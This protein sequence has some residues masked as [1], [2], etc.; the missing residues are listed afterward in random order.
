MAE[1]E[2]SNN[3]QQLWYIRREGKVRGPFPCGAVR[4]SVLLGRVRLDDEASMDRTNWKRVSS[5][6]DVVPPEV[7]KALESGDLETLDLLRMREDERSGR[8]RRTAKDDVEFKERRHGERRRQ[9]DKLVTRHREAKAELLDLEERRKKPYVGMLVVSLLVIAAVGGG[10]YIGS[11][12]AIQE[13]DCFAAPAPGVNWRNCR[14]DETVAE[15]SDLAGAQ[16][17]NAVLRQARLSGSSF[18]GADLKYSDFTG[19]DLSYGEFI[20]AA[21]KGVN[22]QNAD[23]TNA[24]LTGSDLSFA[25]LSG[26]RLG[27]AKLGWA[28]LDGAIWIDGKTCGVGSLGG[29]KK[30]PE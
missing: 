2:N 3:K 8:E 19:A 4:R 17:N 27:G 28:R 22:L 23:L 14:L 12:Q 21:M 29:C 20:N 1:Q 11:P 30:V 9:E 6:P 25:N 10:L 24:D 7:R 18:K 15:N 16:I 5:V 13:P 26:A